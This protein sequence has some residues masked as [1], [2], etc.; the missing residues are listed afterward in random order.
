MNNSMSGKRKNKKKIHK[1]KLTREDYIRIIGGMG[2][3]KRGGGGGV[4]RGGTLAPETV[5]LAH[6]MSTANRNVKQRQ[7]VVDSM[8][9]H[10]VR[11]IGRMM[12]KVLN[13]KRKLPKK[14]ISKLLRDRKLIDAIVNGKGSIN[15]RKKILKLKLRNQKGGFLGPL[16]PLALSLAKPAIQTLGKIF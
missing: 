7:A 14:E 15:T 16:L 1:K 11:Q 13:M 2:G 5:M 4:R 6:L 12:K 8:N 10:Q 3:K 9:D